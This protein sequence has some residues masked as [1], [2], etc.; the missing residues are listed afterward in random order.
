VF[1][2]SVILAGD[3]AGVSPAGLGAVFYPGS[4]AALTLKQANA[5]RAIEGEWTRL[6]CL[7]ATCISEAG[8]VHS[9]DSFRIWIADCAGT[10]SQVDIVVSGPEESTYCGR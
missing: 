7:N 2:L 9:P 5:W 4:P 1:D 10:D 6:A 8:C 3:Q